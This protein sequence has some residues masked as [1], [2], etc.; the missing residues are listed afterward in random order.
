MIH[1][2]RFI[3]F[4]LL[5]PLFCEH[6]D[7]SGRA[8]LR[9]GSQNTGYSYRLPG[10]HFRG[11]YP[12]SAKLHKT[13][14][15]PGDKSISDLIDS[16]GN[17]L[18]FR[19]VGEFDPNF[20]NKLPNISYSL[21]PS[22]LRVAGSLVAKGK[23]FVMVVAEYNINQD[24]LSPGQW[25]YDS[26][27]TPT[28]KV[29][30]FREYGDIRLNEVQVENP[31]EGPSERNVVAVINGNDIAKVFDLL[32]DPFSIRDLIQILESFPER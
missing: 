28:M 18:L 32:P 6:S 17:I 25:G 11:N 27:L 8:C 13:V 4:C 5:I 24:R 7:A 29:S 26:P 3:L 15:V 12:E 21:S 19:V 2:S 20:R 10:K 16:S 14:M 31:N 1:I 30:T 23:G 22:I 9:L